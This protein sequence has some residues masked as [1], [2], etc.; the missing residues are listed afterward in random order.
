MAADVQL[1][2][3]DPAA[4]AVVAQRW[5]GSNAVRDRVHEVLRRPPDH[6][7]IGF[8]SWG[9]ITVLEASRISEAHYGDGLTPADVAKLA[10]ELPSRW[11]WW[12]LYIDW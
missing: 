6:Q 2:V 12:A 9:N 1:V 3:I 5:I 8:A 4:G 10:L 7:S 11:F